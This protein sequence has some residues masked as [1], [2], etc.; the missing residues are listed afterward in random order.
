MKRTRQEY[1]D[2]LDET[3][4][5]YGEDVSR[6]GLER[7]GFGNNGCTYLAQNGNM[8]AVGR[9]L[10]NPGDFDQSLCVQDLIT[11]FGDNQF[12]EEYRGFRKDF[13]SK[14]QSLHDC[15][16]NWCPEGLTHLGT[17]SV[18][19]IRKWIDENVEK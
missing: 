13:W 15:N 16:N 2:L 10:R 3:I 17:D 6:R 1:H 14:L 12:K 18:R 11:D 8:C 19:K 7:N 4:R 9:C 5:H